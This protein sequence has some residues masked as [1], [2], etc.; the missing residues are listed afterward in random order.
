MGRVARRKVRVGARRCAPF[1]GHKKRQRGA[2]G[3]AVPPLPERGLASA[4]CAS[5]THTHTHTHTAAGLAA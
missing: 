3:P 2:Q 5:F 1:H 4:T